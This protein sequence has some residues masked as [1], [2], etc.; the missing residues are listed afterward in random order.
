ML[1][2][3][4]PV[5]VSAPDGQKSL[6]AHYPAGSVALQHA[7]FGG[8]SFYAPGPNTVDLTTAKEATLGYSVLFEQGF[9]FNIGGKLPGLYGGN[10]DSG[11]IGCS[12]GKRSDECFSARLMW[13]ADGAGEMYTYLPPSFAA[14]NAVCNVKPLS[15]CNPVY[16][17][18]IGRGSFKFT[19][20][21]RV[22]VSER[23]RLNDVGQSNGQL[24]LFF[25]GQSVINVGGL[26]LRNSDQ[27][28]IRGIQMQTFFGGH[29]TAFESPKSQDAFFS[30]F[31]VSITETL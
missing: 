3:L 15:D 7:P 25:N 17:A 20:G 30:D 16:G 14:N 23:V 19:A 9:E 5:Y 28:R 6:Q 10:S 1:S 13:R 2:A 8:F 12:G 29:E 22:T 4:K 27:G 21:E 24:Q 26:V 31:S 18:S 11:A